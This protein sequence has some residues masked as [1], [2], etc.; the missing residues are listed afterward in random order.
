MA[1]KISKNLKSKTLLWWLNKNPGKIREADYDPG[2]T[3]SDRNPDGWAYDFFCA[4]GWSSNEDPNQPLHTI[5]EYTVKDML[6]QLRN[7]RPCD[8]ESCK[9]ELEKAQ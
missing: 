5:I 9:R 1:T 4:P 7:L 3:D 8:C 6:D 2:Y